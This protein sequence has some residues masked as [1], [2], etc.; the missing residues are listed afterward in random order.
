[1]SSLINWEVALDRQSQA[2]R[3]TRT[4]APGRLTALQRLWG[5]SPG[6]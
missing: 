1:M 6:R 5:K 4:T 3:V 2:Q